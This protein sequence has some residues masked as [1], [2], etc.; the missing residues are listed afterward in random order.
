MKGGLSTGVNISS[1]L[2]SQPAGQEISV[3]AGAAKTPG[4]SGVVQI[5]GRFVTSAWTF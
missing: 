4:T 2:R 3:K 1:D 5:D